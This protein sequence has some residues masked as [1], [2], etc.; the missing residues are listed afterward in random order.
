M[1]QSDKNL[2]MKVSN[3]IETC[4]PPPETSTGDTL[5]GQ[6]GGQVGRGEGALFWV[7]GWE[8]PLGW[9]VRFS[10]VS[11]P[12]TLGWV[13]CWILWDTEGNE[14]WVSGGN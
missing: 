11:E 7:G 5:W 8:S 6:G 14:N 3:C 9:G 4:G 10:Q 13:P 1:R 12:L 2:V